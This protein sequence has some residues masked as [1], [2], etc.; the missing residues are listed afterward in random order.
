M[1]IFLL[2]LS[3]ALFISVIGAYFSILGLSTIFPGSKY[4]V[5]VMGIALE[6]AKIVTVL[7]L[8][9]NW[10]KSK[11]LMKLYFCFA[12]FVLMGITS[13]GIFG[14]LSKAHIEH[15]NKASN[16][17]TKI[18]Q[19]E[20]SINAERK[21]L[22]QYEEYI[23]SLKKSSTTEEDNKQKEIDRSS[24]RL[25]E[26]QNKLKF[27]I[28]T[29]QKRI[30][31]LTE[32]LI[33]LDQEVQNTIKNNSGFFSDKKK[34]LAKIEEKQEEERVKIKNNIISYE[35]NI[36]LFREN[37]EIKSLE[38]D[39][40]INSIRNQQNKKQDNQENIEIYNEKIKSS[41]NIISG[42]EKEKSKLGEVIR[43]VEAEIGPLKYFIGMVNDLGIASI[44]SDQAVRLIIIVIMIVFDPLAIILVIAAQVSFYG[45]K[46][47]INLTYEKLNKKI[48]KPHI[49]KKNN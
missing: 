28:E 5:I 18:E 22:S 4:S 10:A 19:I 25:N 32:R 14:F 31:K 37:Y 47:R 24:K 42:L 30:D 36:K 26:L 2:T 15:Q 39:S 45:E 20:T 3:S 6:I 43:S 21:F 44:S 8:H 49:I 48:K 13:L 34:A 35:N 38:I 40:F 29:E 9:K 7:W 46:E 12:V 33:Y 16:E 41:I 23:E 27:D 17:V 1:K 11:F